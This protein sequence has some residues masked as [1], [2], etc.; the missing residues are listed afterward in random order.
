M[1]EESV[2]A[3]PMDEKGLSRWV[4]DDQVNR[5]EPTQGM[6]EGYAQAKVWPG[7]EPEELRF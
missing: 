6:P 3:G 4:G 2:L 1:K 5:M 7:R